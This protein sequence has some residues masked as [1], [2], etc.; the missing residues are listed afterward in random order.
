MTPLT[1]TLLTEQYKML[2]RNQN[3]MNIMHYHYQ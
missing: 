3:T 1:K 2:C